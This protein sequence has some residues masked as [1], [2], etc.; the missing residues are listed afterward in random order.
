MDRGIE[1]GPE[2]PVAD[3]APMAVDAEALFNNTQADHT[4]LRLWLR[5]LTTTTLIE[6]GIRRRLRTEFGVTLPRFDL[7]AQLRREPD[8]LIL[9]EISRRMMVSAG[10]VTGLIERLVASGHVERHPNPT[11]RRTQT[12]SLTSEGREA[13]DAMAAA[14]EGWVADVLG[15]LKPDD[16]ERI[17]LRLAQV[18]ASARRA[19]ADDTP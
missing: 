5:L 12:V 19:F 16:M 1:D 4:E 15:D 2:T 3:T 7:M 14:H 6:T 18:K 11:D 9:S 17:M 13:F 10:N 8:G